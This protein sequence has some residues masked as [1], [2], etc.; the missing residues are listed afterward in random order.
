MDTVFPSFP[1]YGNFWKDRDGDFEQIE[2]ALKPRSQKIPLHKALYGLG[3]IT[4]SSFL[5]KGKFIG[6]NLG[7][8]PLDKFIYTL[9]VD[10]D[11]PRQG[12]S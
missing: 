7:I 4:R 11:T 5:R 2:N 6:D 1:D 9:R 12:Q 3:C 10:P 8:L